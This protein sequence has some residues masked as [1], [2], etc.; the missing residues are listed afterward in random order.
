[1]KIVFF[2][3]DN[4]SLI[5]IASLI[6]TSHTTSAIVTTPDAKKGRGQHLS[7]SPLKI[8]ARE[9]D[10]PCL[11]PDNLSDAEVLSVLK[12]LRADLFFI[13][14][15][16]KIL[17]SEVLCLPRLYCITIHPSLLPKYRGPSPIPYTLLHGD[18]ETGFSVIKL[19]EKVDSGDIIY[20]ETIAIDTMINAHELSNTIALYAAGKLRDILEMIERGT[21][22]FRP[23]DERNASYAPF[24]KKEDGLLDWNTSSEKVHNRIRALIP[25][26]CAY[27]YFRHKMLKIYKS[28]PSRTIKEIHPE[29][30]GI[31]VEIN[32]QGWMTVKTHDAS[33]RL[34]EV[35]YEGKKRMNAY[36]WAKGQ[37]VKEGEKLG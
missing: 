7:A 22:R 24:L 18:T 12:D 19:S 14:S 34:L 36:E 8:C 28:H 3:S 2:G 23:Q 17:P 27:T 10:I 20:Q 33:L 31:I 35:Q 25:W 13:V 29:Q 15:Y 26:P 1:M 30:P 37:R 5:I 6:H 32:K 16:G 11:Q 9:H 21:V 4:F